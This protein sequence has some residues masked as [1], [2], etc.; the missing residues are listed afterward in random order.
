MLQKMRIYVRR[1][2]VA[3][4][5]LFVSLGG[6]AY[7]GSK[8]GSSDIKR[9]AVKSKHVAKNAL[10]GQDVNE[11]RLAV[12]RTVARVRST[13]PVR[14]RG[15]LVKTIPLDDATIRQRSGQALIFA[16]RGSFS[17]NCSPSL[18]TGEITVVV[19]LNGRAIA[20]IESGPLITSGSRAVDGYAVGAGGPINAFAGRDEALNRTLSAEIESA[21]CPE[22]GTI[23]VDEVAIDVIGSR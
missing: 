2:H 14:A 23:D 8:I 6:T 9:D 16:T 20:K 3:L 1:H 21:A 5:A 19:K 12:A 4:L 7:A 15:A 22:G 10:K 17:W 11:A 13:A 18:A